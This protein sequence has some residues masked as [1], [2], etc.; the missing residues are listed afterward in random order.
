M[1]RIKAIRYIFTIVLFTFALLPLAATAATVNINAPEWLGNLK[2]DKKQLTEIK[3][4]V[5]KALDSPIDT[6]L[7]C[8]EVRGDCVVRPA[9]E[10][11]YKGN[12]YR[13][14]VIYLHTK[15]HASKTIGQ[16]NGKWPTIVTGLEPKKSPPK[17]D[18]K[19]SKSKKKEKKKK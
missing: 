9:R 2:L 16:T 3:K 15:G 11:T 10:W 1:L 5:T 6:E 13:E 7:E 14:I 12:R 19:K 4:Q 18:K 17:K 8:G